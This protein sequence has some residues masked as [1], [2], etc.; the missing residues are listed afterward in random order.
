VTQPHVVKLGGS[1]LSA[2]TTPALLNDWLERAGRTHPGEHRILI[3]GGGEPVDWLRRVDRQNP[4]GDTTA[5]WAAIALMDANA[6][7]AAGWRP[8][9][10]L[11]NDWHKLQQ[12]GGAPGETIFAA[13]PFLR[14][15]EPLSPGTTLPVGW[16][17]TSDCIAARVAVLLDARLTLLKS[18]EVE[19]PT[20]KADWVQLANKGFVDE[21]FPELVEALDRVEVDA[22]G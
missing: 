4:L 5:H 22:L 11:T 13:G 20:S 21:F 3:V 8:G 18:R 10:I 19:L 1:L 15:C 9:A 2:A 14:N 12:R 7:V 16:Q 6:Q 17:V